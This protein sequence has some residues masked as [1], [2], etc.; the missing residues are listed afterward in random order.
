MQ[1]KKI[2]LFLLCQIGSFSALA[3]EKSKVAL[4]TDSLL[5]IALAQTTDSAKFQRFL[6]IS[7]FL[8]ER[9]TAKAFHYFREA[10]K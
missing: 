7:Y 8:S 10:K 9:D 1:L 3:Q 5:Q 4:Y 6:D 2:I